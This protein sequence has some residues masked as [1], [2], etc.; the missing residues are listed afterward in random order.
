[1]APTSTPTPT[2]DTSPS[3]SPSPSGT[4]PPAETPPDTRPETP[5]RTRPTSP[6]TVRVQPYRRGNEAVS[7]LW[8]ISRAHLDT[9]LSDEQ[10]AEAREQALPPDTQVADFALRELINLNP[11]YKLAENPGHIEPGWEFDVT[12]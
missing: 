10:K 6:E 2:P 4:K 9:L 5:P 7:T 8:G 12:R 11:K 1:V 3:P